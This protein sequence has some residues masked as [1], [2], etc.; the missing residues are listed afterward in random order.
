MTAGATADIDTFLPAI[1][2]IIRQNQP[3]QPGIE[4]RLLESIETRILAT[5]SLPTTNLRRAGL[6]EAAEIVRAVFA[7]QRQPGTDPLR[8]KLR[9]EAVRRIMDGT[10][11]VVLRIPSV[12]GKSSCV[13]DEIRLDKP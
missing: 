12:E 1:E 8:Q 6:A 5:Y 4:L 13:V 10:A 3:T 9:D 2:A 11:A 7:E